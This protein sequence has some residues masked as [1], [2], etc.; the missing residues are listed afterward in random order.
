MNKL[1]IRS[2]CFSVSGKTVKIVKNKQIISIKYDIIA[3]EKR[4]Q[5]AIIT[6]KREK[7]IV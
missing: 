3:L 2:L 5:S 4:F 1:Q 6:L 7:E